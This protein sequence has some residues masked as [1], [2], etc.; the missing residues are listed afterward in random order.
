MTFGRRDAAAAGRYEDETMT[1]EE[2][3]E[4]A[5]EAAEKAADKA[6]DKAI[7]RFML[8]LGIDAR[9]PQAVLR[10][11]AHMTHLRRQYEACQLVQKHTLKTAVG[12][13]ITAIAA[14]V[15]LAFGLQSRP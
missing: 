2:M 5:E 13:V 11:Q 15:L 6:A 7:A 4:I 3:R 9:D 8:V 14:Y 10:A 1:R 12:A